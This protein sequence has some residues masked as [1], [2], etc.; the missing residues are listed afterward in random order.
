MYSGASFVKGALLVATDDATSCTA[1]VS[2]YVIFICV[3]VPSSVNR[4]SSEYGFSLG[5]QQ[6]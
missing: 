6:C 2:D 5:G 4:I 3:R 1:F